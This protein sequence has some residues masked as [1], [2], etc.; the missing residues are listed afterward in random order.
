MGPYWVRI[1]SIGFD[2]DLVLNRRQAIIEAN[3]VEFLRRIYRHVR[4]LQ[5]HHNEH[6]GVSNHPRP[7]CFLNC[8]FRRNWWKLEHEGLAPPKP[9]LK[10]RSHLADLTAYLSRPWWSGEVLWSRERTGMGLGRSWEVGELGRG[11]PDCSRLFWTV[12]NN[13]EWSGMKSSRG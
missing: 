8:L 12:Q 2:E 3:D 9:Q 5:W 11:V 6:N 1:N 10:P 13:R 4:P 7:D